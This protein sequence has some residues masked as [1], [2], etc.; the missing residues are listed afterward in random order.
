MSTLGRDDMMYIYYEIC[1]DA[2]RYWQKG[3]TNKALSLISIAAS[4]AYN[5]NQFFADLSLEKLLAE[6]S[7]K[8]L[9]HQIITQP[10]KNRC[11]FIDTAGIDNRGLTQQYLR[12]LMANEFEFIYI[13]EDADIDKVTD[14]L[15]EVRE[16]DKGEVCLLGDC[17]SH[18]EMITALQKEV[19]SYAPSFILLHL[20]PWDV[21]ALSAIFSISGV[22]KYNINLTDEAYWLGVTFFDYNIEFRN[23]GYTISLEK[24]G[25]REEQLLYLPYYPIFPHSTSFAG[26]SDVINKAS[27]K[28]LTGGN[29]YKFFDGND[30]FFQLMDR[31]L[32]SIPT[33][34]I[35][36]AGSGDR[37]SVV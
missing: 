11:V 25:F 32:E 33:A 34:I 2:H 7:S 20:M 4:F 12:A 19:I 28:I 14:I 30:T 1:K 5:Y 17:K 37:K 35:V 24:R 22:K 10:I 3:N 27:I 23:Y 6:I 16:Y 15:R 9:S 8:T 26:F 18:V 21:D 36:L 13:Y 31:L 29:Y